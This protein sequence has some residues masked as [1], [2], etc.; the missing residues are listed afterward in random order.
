LSLVSIEDVSHADIYRALGILEGKLD[1]VASALTQRNREFEN[2]LKR[3]GDLEKSVAKGMGIALTFSVVMPIVI[4]GLGLI[5][6]ARVQGAAGVHQAPARAAVTGTTT[7]DPLLLPQGRSGDGSRA[8]EWPAI[9][10]CSADG[11]CAR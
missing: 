7:A 6:T 11:R 3:I 4:G 9:Q 5:F 10:S 1:A 8:Q 2:A